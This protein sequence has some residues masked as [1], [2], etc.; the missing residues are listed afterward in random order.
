M[1]PIML[2]GDQEKV[3]SQIASEVGI[4][5]YIA[6][7]IPSQKGEVIETLKQ[8]KKRVI[9]VGDGINDAIALV[10]AD[11]GIAMGS[12]TNV[13]L[14]TG[15]VI[16]L[17]NDLRAIPILIKQSK[18]IQR[19]IA[20]NLVFA[21]IYNVIA[22]PVAMSGQLTPA[23]AAIAMSLSSISVLVNSLT[24]RRRIKRI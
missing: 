13:A 7:V 5:H 16:L 9:M 1:N 12:G 23:I 24:L 11:V 15:D 19:K 18:R 10:K 6:E 8:E 20:E 21:F 3:A 14:E 22:I 17:R 2:T 4:N